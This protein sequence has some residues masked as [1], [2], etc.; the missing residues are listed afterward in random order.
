M[1]SAFDARTAPIYAAFILI[2]TNLVS[3]FSIPQL[4]I[5]PNLVCWFDD[6][7]DFTGICVCYYYW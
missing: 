4:P 1:S 2:D 7:T 5:R 6:D 3:L